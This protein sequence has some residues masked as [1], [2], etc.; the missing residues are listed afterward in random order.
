MLPS[1]HHGV[2]CFGLVSMFIFIF[3]AH[4]I[5]FK[6]GLLLTRYI[7]PWQGRIWPLCCA[8]S[9]DT[10]LFTIY[11]QTQCR[12]I[13][14]V[15]YVVCNIVLL[16]INEVRSHN[17][18]GKTPFTSTVSVSDQ[19]FVLI[20]CMAGLMSTPPYQVTPLVC[21]LQSS[22]TWCTEFINQFIIFMLSTL[23]ESFMRSVVFR[24]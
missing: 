22:C 19:L 16:C 3:S 15:Y 4:M 8:L 21:I 17:T 1:L 24:Y 20:F 23:R 2:P 6:L 5:F 18:K 9:W 12:S 11:Q 13:I 14:F 7:C 10:P